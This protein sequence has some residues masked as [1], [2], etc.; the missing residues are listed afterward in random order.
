MLFSFFHASAAL[1]AVGP[2]A[3]G[4][5]GV[6]RQELGSAVQTPQAHLHRGPLGAPRPGPARPGTAASLRLCWRRG[7]P[8][9]R[10]GGAGRWRQT[11]AAPA[12]RRCP[13]RPL[14]GRG[15]PETGRPGGAGPVPRP[16][17]PCPAPA[18]VAAGDTTTP[19]RALGQGL[20]CRPACCV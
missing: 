18:P 3:S 2:R 7:G 6:G 10:H 11:A 4:E 13:A 1:R 16:E 19:R 20:G 14:R 8:G 5:R 9:P 12:P 17:P 15:G